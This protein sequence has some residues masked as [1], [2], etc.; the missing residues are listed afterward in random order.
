MQFRE[1]NTGGIIV[2]MDADERGLMY[3]A[4]DFFMKNCSGDTLD[5]LSDFTGVAEDILNVLDSP[6]IVKV[7]D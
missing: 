3:N 2:Q 1:N 4:L 6:D 5:Y 7:G